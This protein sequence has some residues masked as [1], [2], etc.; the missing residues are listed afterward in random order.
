MR[1]LEITLVLTLI[2]RIFFNRRLPK[3]THFTAIIMTLLHLLIEGYRW[4]MLG[5]Y[6][7]AGIDALLYFRPARKPNWAVS[8]G[9]L[10]LLIIFIAPPI[11]FPIPKV[12]APTGEFPIGT[13]QLYLVDESRT[14]PYA[15]EPDA[16]RELMLQI[17]FPSN[18]EINAAFAPWVDDADLLA[19]AISN[20]IEMPAW[21][22]DHLI[23]AK[24][25]ARMTRAV[26]S[27]D[28]PA[29][30]LLFSHGWGG[31]RA[32]NTALVENL[33]SHGFIVVAVEHSYAAVTTVFPDGRVAAHNPDTLPT[34]VSEAEYE[35]AADALVAQ[36]AEDMAF[37]IDQLKTFNQSGESFLYQELDLENI[38]V[39]GHSTGGGAA[40]QFCAQDSRCKAGFGMDAW[41]TPVS[42][43]VL[44]DGPD[45]PFFYLYSELWP[46]EKNW[47][48]FDE[49]YSGQEN[50]YGAYVI[51][52]TSHYDFSD[53]PALSPLAPSLGL[54]GPIEGERIL[55]LL[56]EITVAYF[57]QTLGGEHP[58]VLKGTVLQFDEMIPTP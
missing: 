19:P 8:A 32:Q 21:F 33:A 10:I 58:S 12:P 46:S 34:D 49:L 3:W 43:N 41:L 55:N 51:Q 42:D 11:I 35:I 29:P 44:A 30:V 14:D 39:L 52:G 9:S 53:L 37:V 56:N 17:W 45:Q 40:V 24:T 6:L 18:A 16:P 22:L 15:P 36:W 1:T 48:L 4:Q 26:L 25:D 47:A 31:F 27:Q 7:F 50:R 5:L 57:N 38:G 2:I 28:S 23:Y 54:K 13:T 20:W